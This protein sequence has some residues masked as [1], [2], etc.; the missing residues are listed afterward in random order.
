MAGRRRRRRPKVTAGRSLSHG[1]R[2]GGISGGG[3]MM[4]AT[5][6]LFVLLFGGSAPEKKP[7]IIILLARPGAASRS[8]F[9]FNLFLGGWERRVAEH[10]QTHINVHRCSSRSP[11][12]PCVCMYQHQI[13]MVSFS[14]VIYVR[15]TT[16]KKAGRSHEE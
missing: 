15:D 6:C 9:E 5:Y 13:V 12:S 8:T 3:I 4:C 1:R 16:S 14:H 10:D 2:G 7:L 11:S